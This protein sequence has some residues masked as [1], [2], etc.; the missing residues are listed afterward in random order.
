MAQ[1]AL[2]AIWDAVYAALNV[3]AM[4]TTL[5]CDVH[6]HVPA[7]PT[8]P[9]LRMSSPTENRQDTFG[10]DGKYVTFQ[11]HIFTSSDDYEGAGQAQ[12]ILNAAITLLHEVPLVI[13]GQVLI[14]CQYENG[15]DA[16]DDDVEGTTVKHYVGMFGV[17]VLEA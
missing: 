14:I 6:D 16:G 10:K 1:S 8:F 17:Q 11:L 9:Y 7:D 13:A 4:T 5:S 15:F 12:G 2:P 3:P